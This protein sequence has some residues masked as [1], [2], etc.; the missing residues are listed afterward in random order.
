MNGVI[1]TMTPGQNGPE[2]WRRAIQHNPAVCQAFDVWATHPYPESYPPHY[3]HH[4]GVPFIN[5]VK[6]IDSYL[7]DLDLVASECSAQGSPRRG[8]PVMITE[9]VYG[10]RLV[11]AY[12]GY[13][14]T[15]RGP[16]CTTDGPCEF[17]L[18]SEYNVAAFTEFWHKWP[19]ILAV[20][21]FILNNWSWDPFAF[22]SRG[23]G[24]RSDGA[25]PDWC[26]SED[27]SGA[28]P[29]PPNYTEGARRC[30]LPDAPYPQ[31]KAVLDIAKPPPAFLEPY[32]GLVGTI[33][34]RVRRA[35]DASP[36]G[37]ATVNTD[38]YQ[39]GG[40]TLSD[41]IYVVREVPV[42]DY[43]L[44]VEK[45]GYE[46]RSGS[47]RVEAG[48]ESVID[49]ELMHT[50]VVSRGIYFQNQGTCSDCNLFAP[51]LGESFVVPDDVGFIKFAA[52]M[53][54]VG[55][56]TMKFSI[57]EDGPTGTRVGE[58]VT[59]YLEWGGEMIGAEWPGA[60]I[61]VEPG[62]TYFLKVER[63]DGAGVYL[64]ATDANPYAEGMAFTGTTPHPGWDLLATIRGQTPAINVKLGTL[65]G[66]VQ[67]VGNT[68][69]VGARVRSE[70]GGVTTSGADGRYSLSLSEGAHGVSA[71]LDG[72]VSSSQTAIA[73]LEGQTQVL[74]FTLEAEDAPPPPPPPPPG[75]ALVNG[76]FS[77][78]LEGWNVWTERGELGLVAANGV[79]HLVGRGHNGGIYQQF[80]TGGAGAEVTVEG[81]WE[82]RPSV[83]NAQW[84]E[85][86]VI[87]GAR[88]PSDGNDL[89]AAEA[90]VVMIY[91]N[92]TWATPNGW[93]GNMRN[94]APVASVGSFVAS[95]DVATIVLKSGN[96]LGVDSGV[97]FDDIEVGTPASPPPV[98]QPPIARLVATPS[99]GNVPLDVSFDASSSSDP[100]GD[101]LS[102]DWNFGDGASGTGET[103]SHR[104]DNAGLYT[105]V[106]TVDDG[107]GGTDA[108]STT[109]DVGLAA[110]VD[111]LVANGD[112]SLGLEGWSFWRERGAVTPVVEGGQA[113]RRSLPTVR[114]GRRGP[115]DHGGRVLGFRAHRRGIAVGGDSR[116][117]WSGLTYRRSGFEW[118]PAERDSVT[119]ARHVGFAVGMERGDGAGELRLIG[120]RGD[121][122]A[123]ERQRSGGEY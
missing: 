34:G 60:G 86:L 52:A 39:F 91:K 59:A 33:R 49:F 8:F 21:P 65:T 70:A 113:Q 122:R 109:V 74:D 112:F 117:R 79:V 18:A 77:R 71:S 63:A 25:R 47:V 108:A 9:T 24:S 82:S 64:F 28:T 51:Y 73:I 35:D 57:L 80:Q 11:I 98:N 92:D 115:R 105:V 88:L 100:D 118:S 6:T 83:A 114:D 89:S 1:R 32:R 55:G 45:V 31:Y 123:Q 62:R 42:G 2:W 10:D 81:F 120:G 26:P 13:P 61:P 121:D 104:Y 56:V 107:W 72:Y 50:G 17:G 48:E 116:D 90:D 3:N 12:E 102:F 40:P 99:D 22:V 78:G 75:G 44:S 93:S 41:G 68:P 37:F 95:S 66:V 36:V 84:A 103:S 67:D 97:V 53:P 30:G 106:V 23:S 20:H 76:D 46:S 119:Q 43:T 7:L 94:H 19:E 54:N 16:A 29:W 14:K 111:N 87:D 101:G 69:L 96:L 110:P 4:D 38:G 58:P 27:I 5:Q 85:V 15:T